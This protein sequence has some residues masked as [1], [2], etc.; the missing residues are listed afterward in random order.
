MNLHQHYSTNTSGRDFIVG[1]LQGCYTLLLDTL[2]KIQFDFNNDRLFAV[3][4]L[5]DRGPESFDCAN[6]IYKPWFKTS[7]G[8]HEQMMYMTILHNHPTYKQ[9]WLSNGGLWHLSEDKQLLIDIAKRFET[10]PLIISVGEKENRFNIVHAELIP[11]DHRSLISDSDIDNWT[12]NPNQID[13]M[14]WGR[15]IVNRKTGKLSDCIG[16]ITNNKQSNELSPTFVGHSV[17]K[18]HPIQC[19]QQIYIDTGAVYSLHNPKPEQY[20]LTIASP[21]EQI[22]YIYTYPWKTVTKL[23]FNKMKKYI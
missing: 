9:C 7:Q 6:L 2:E 20:P 22:F 1:D 16:D 10:L 5:I 13:N 12:F 15:E 11:A 4:D 23:P 18:F 19:E 21:Q 3:G 14:L 17:V 8:N